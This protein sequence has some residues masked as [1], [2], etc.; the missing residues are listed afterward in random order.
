MDRYPGY[1][2]SLAGMWAAPL[3]EVD[4]KIKPLPLRLGIREE[5]ARHSEKKN[6]KDSAKLIWNYETKENHAD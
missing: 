3:R 5:K 6:V 1:G 2:D 4:H